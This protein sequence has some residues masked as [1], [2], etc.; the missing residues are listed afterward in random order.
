MNSWVLRNPSMATFVRLTTSIGF[1]RSS[2]RALRHANRLEYS[3]ASPGKPATNLSV[4][5]NIASNVLGSLV[6]KY[7]QSTTPLP[8]Y[9]SEKLET[10]RG[11]KAKKALT[12]EAKEL[13]TAQR[14]ARIGLKLYETLSAQDLSGLIQGLNRF[15]I[16]TEIQAQEHGTIPAV[17]DMAKMDSQ[18]KLE[19]HIGMADSGEDPVNAAVGKRLS[20]VYKF[21]GW[22]L[23][24]K[25]FWKRLN[26][27]FEQQDVSVPQ[28]EESSA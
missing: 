22:T 23:A 8:S 27:C 6:A 19:T 17:H 10:T 21:D 13:L 1:Q 2:T 14:K 9:L 20:K 5:N 7:R 16:R 28:I 26:D 25:H 18:W 11:L 3:T 24:T 15:D 4:K 12:H